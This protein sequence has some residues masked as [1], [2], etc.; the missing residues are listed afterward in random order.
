MKH[1]RNFALIGLSLAYSLWAGEEFNLTLTGG[2]TSSYVWAKTEGTSPNRYITLKAKKGSLEPVVFLSKEYV[3]SRFEMIA[4][5]SLIQSGNANSEAGLMIRTS[6][7]E[8][9][10]WAKATLTKDNRVLFQRKVDGVVEAAQ[11][12]YSVLPGKDVYFKAFFNVDRVDFYISNT[13][14]P[15]SDRWHRVGPPSYFPGHYFAGFCLIPKSGTTED[16]GRIS[17]IN[18]LATNSTGGLAKASASAGWVTDGLKWI[19]GSLRSAANGLQSLASAAGDV[20]QSTTDVIIEVFIE[21][22]AEVVTGVTVA[23]TNPVYEKVFSKTIFAKDEFGGLEWSLLFLNPVVNGNH[24]D[25][26]LQKAFQQMKTLSEDHLTP[27][28]PNKTQLERIVQARKN[29]DI[30]LADM[31]TTILNPGIERKHQTVE[32]SMLYFRFVPAEVLAKMD[33]A[34][35][36]C[37][38]A[39]QVEAYNPWDWLTTPVDSYDCIKT[40]VQ[41]N[42]S[43]DSYKQFTTGA[44]K[45]GIML[46]ATNYAFTLNLMSLVDEDFHYKFYGNR[47][48]FNRG[49]LEWAERTSPFY[50]NNNIPIKAYAAIALGELPHDVKDTYTRLLKPALAR[51]I[52][53]EGVYA[54][55]TSYLNYVNQEVGPLLAMAYDNGWLTPSEFPANYTKTGTWLLRSADPSGNIP[56]VD[57]GN[58]GRHFWLGTY[59]RITDNPQ[60]KG[61]AN[62]TYY[63][64]PKFEYPRD[65]IMTNRKMLSYPMILPESAPSFTQA[66]FYGSIGKLN[67]SPATGVNSTLTIIAESGNQKYE[68]FGHDQQ[69]NSSISINRHVAGT[70]PNK[71]EV[72][73]LIIDP[74]YGGYS[75]R[76]KMSWNMFHNTVLIAGSGVAGN[77]ALSW[78]TAQGLLMDAFPNASFIGVDLIPFLS[79]DDMH[80]V[81]NLTTSLTA[82]AFDAFGYMADKLPKA[83]AGGGEAYL[84]RK[85]TDGMV[86]RQAYEAAGSD[87]NRRAVFKYGNDFVVIDA[88]ASTRKNYEVHYNLPKET[89]RSDKNLYIADNVGESKVMLAIFSEDEANSQGTLDVHNDYPTQAKDANG[90]PILREVRRLHFKNIT[91]NQSGGE[92]GYI[93]VISPR[94]KGEAIPYTY[95]KATCPN[96][97]VCVE[98]TEGDYV[99]YFFLNDGSLTSPLS[100][101]IP[102][103]PRNVEFETDARYGFVKFNTRT[104]AVANAQLYDYSKASVFKVALNFPV[105]GVKAQGTISNTAVN[106]TTYSLGVDGNTATQTD[107]RFN[108]ASRRASMSAIT[109]LLLN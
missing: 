107:R 95:R 101:R 33:K 27:I 40:S 103:G 26:G 70:G 68:G 15:E 52:D 98:R 14:S 56:N 5:V 86:I 41:A 102:S 42:N 55:G 59:A 24:L 48:N 78:E 66:D 3:T 74:P 75:S 8:D 39:L 37:H 88:V 67:I 25:G 64:E 7:A 72:D 44:D 4:K 106:G 20:L 100:V 79:V 18:F 76:E 29:A 109:S 71:K 30:Y 31:V 105:A 65:N 104:G 83:Y 54:E 90:L 46:E 50:F 28:D 12:E 80:V 84:D 61:Y 38:D 108:L 77:G 99:T 57:D 2:N 82:W 96:A 85:Y 17:Q 89:V 32:P 16:I 35:K 97:S 23:V 58:A 53:G 94:A 22:V 34:I 11:L 45:D 9:A 91:P 69:D 6:R 81:G 43:Y 92:F 73:T 87:Q 47:K 13:L 63:M 60:F 10:D 93:T 49:L 62:G 36:Y 19:K 21:P 1:F 51:K